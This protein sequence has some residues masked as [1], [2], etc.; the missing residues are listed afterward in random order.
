MEY[1]F[2]YLDVIL[3]CIGDVEKGRANVLNPVLSPTTENGRIHINLL[4]I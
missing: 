1:G 4:A 3:D 2:D